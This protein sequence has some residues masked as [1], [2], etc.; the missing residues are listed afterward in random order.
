MGSHSGR[1]LSLNKGEVPGP[2]ERDRARGRVDGSER[3]D[4][5]VEDLSFDTSHDR[6]CRGGVQNVPSGV[7]KRGGNPP[8]NKT[9]LPPLHDPPNTGR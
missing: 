7:G 3:T 8:V 5:G 6:L 2:T 1:P 4:R 9:K